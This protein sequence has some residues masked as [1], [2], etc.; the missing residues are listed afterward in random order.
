MNKKIYILICIVLFT[1][2]RKRTYAQGPV[3]PTPFAD[4]NVDDLGDVSD[5][6]QETFFEA[7]KQKGIQNY[8]RAITALDKC[9]ALEPQMAILY[10]ERGK[11]YVFLKKYDPAI[12]DFKKSLELNPDDKDVLKV[13]YDVYYKQRDY[14][15]AEQTVKELI[16]FD[17]QYKEDLARIYTQTK[18]YEE[19]L[20]LIEEL[21]NE[22]GPDLY[23]NQLKNRL[24]IL[25]GNTDRQ[26]KEIEENIASS[27]KS[28]EEY[29]KLIFL[30]SEQGD[31]KK[32]YETALELQKQ[33]PK[34]T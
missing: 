29:L 22:K 34:G 33:N 28:A 32:A 24:Y 3:N 18:R 10:F 27:P 4:E 21:D 14:L 15:A 6:F 13:L 26:V 30:Y 20:D 2:S 19:A 31:S 12:T 23:R 17:S 8:D 1:L 16:V 9:I 7:L 25:S 11:N 5:N